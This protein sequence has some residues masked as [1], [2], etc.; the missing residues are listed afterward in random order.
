MRASLDSSSAMMTPKPEEWAASEADEP[1][2]RFAT[3]H[4]A[5]IATEFVDEARRALEPFGVDIVE[6]LCLGW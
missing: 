6:P 2:N 5:S 1:Q 3:H 4:R